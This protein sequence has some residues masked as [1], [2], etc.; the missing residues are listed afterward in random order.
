MSFT[1]LSAAA[2]LLIALV[3][4]TSA[5]G[6]LQFSSSD[7]ARHW[8]AMGFR[9]SLLVARLA[10]L[11]PY[12]E[13]FLAVGL[14]CTAGWPARAF[15]IAVLALTLAYLWI[16][17]SQY[18]G[19]NAG[20]CPCFGPPQKVTRVTVIRNVWYIALAL[21]VLV[22]SFTAS[23]V[24]SPLLRLIEAWPA[25]AAMGAAVLTYWLST[26]GEA[27]E[28]ED[29]LEYLRLPTPSF[30]AWHEGHAVTLRTLSATGPVLLVLADHRAMA[31]GSAV[32][33][34]PAWREQLPGVRVLAVVRRAEKDWQR[35]LADVRANHQGAE[36]PAREQPWFDGYIFDGTGQVYQGFGMDPAVPASIL[37]GAD[38]L[39]AAGPVFG[40]K[41]MDQLVTDLAEELRAVTQ[42]AAAEA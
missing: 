31:G 8:Y 24:S 34:I 38:G 36:I 14:V 4:V 27:A 10:W 2:A 22:G 18:S 42:G 6:K 32:R 1:F 30:E 25:T 17:W 40:E 26:Q 11:H 3:F 5:I 9:E 39:L 41:A 33:R 29:T 15:A 13:I 35:T 7:R 37:L 20:V 12:G 23:A 16:I 19:R 21:L 28:T